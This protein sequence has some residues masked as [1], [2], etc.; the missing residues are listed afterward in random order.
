MGWLGDLLGTIGD[1]GKVAAPALGF[2]PGVG[3]LAAAGI[4]AGAGALG[5]LNDEDQS[6]G[7]IVGSTLGGAALGTGAHLTGLR[8]TRIG[9]H[10][11]SEAE[12]IENFIKKLK[13]L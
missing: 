11:V 3:P 7:S 1:V 4:G 2:I 10:R 12:H 5:K 9:P 13:L 8:R 6:L